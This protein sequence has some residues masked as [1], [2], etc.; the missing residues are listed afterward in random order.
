MKESPFYHTMKR[1]F[2][3]L[4]IILCVACKDDDSFSTSTGLRLTFSADTLQMDTVFSRTPSSTYAFWVHNQHDDGI[5]IST[6]KLKRGNQSGFRVN[7]DGVYLDNSNGSQTSDVEIRKNDSILVFVELTAVETRKMEPQLVEDDLQFFLESGVEQK[8]VLQA[9]AW[10]ALK[11]YDPEIKTDSV[12]ESDV[13]I[14]VF[15]KMHV[16]EGATLTIRNTTLF[17][18]DS[19]GMVVNGSLKTEHCVMRGDRLDYMFDYLPYDRVSGQW[20]GIRFRESS[21]DNVL[22]DTEIRNASWA[23]VCDSAAIDSLRPRLTMERCIVHNAAGDGVM[24]V[25]TYL[26]LKECQLSNTLGN[27]LSVSGGIAEISKCTLAQFYP[28]SADRAS[29][30]YFGN[31]WSGYPVPLLRLTCEDTIVTGYD[32]DVVMGHPD[33]DESIAFN[34]RFV[35]SLLRTPEVADDTVNFKRIIWE[36]PNDSIQGAKHFVTIDEDNLIYDFHLDSLS[37]AQGMGCY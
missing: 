21:V 23:V 32:E 31:H 30:L 12:I 34:Y 14:V 13:P 15:G 3:L 37:T 26:I 20:E 9:W 24:A 7:V 25:N 18:H 6:V 36:T 10:D 33:D 28:F 5:R 22:I 1:I 29:A 16:A 8:V 17:F 4:A 27:C 11:V 2:Y 35:H 19:S